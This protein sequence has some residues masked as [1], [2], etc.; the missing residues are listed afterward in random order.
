MC[1]LNKGEDLFPTAA[2]RPRLRCTCVRGLLGGIEDLGLNL[3]QL[4][5]PTGIMKKKRLKEKKNTQLNMIIFSPLRL[6][7][8]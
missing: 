6:L 7:E 4:A 8:L 2:I 1:V 5:Q 3:S